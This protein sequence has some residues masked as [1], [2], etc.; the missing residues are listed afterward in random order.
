[1]S[2]TALSSPA[3]DAR[4]AVETASVGTSANGPGHQGHAAEAEIPDDRADV[5]C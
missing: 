4:G 1:M 2:A 5:A 3:D